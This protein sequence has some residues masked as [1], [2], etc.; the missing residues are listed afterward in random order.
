MESAKYTSPLLPLIYTLHKEKGCQAPRSI[1]G[2]HLPMVTV[3]EGAR[4]RESYKAGARRG[5]DTVLQP[6]PHRTALHT[7]SGIYK[8]SPSNKGSSCVSIPSSIELI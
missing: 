7:V 8:D 2:V 4:T 1:F 5:P 3:C 6:A